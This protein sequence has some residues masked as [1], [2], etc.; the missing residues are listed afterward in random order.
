MIT[1][2]HRLNLFG[3]VPKTCPG[4]CDPHD[5]EGLVM[6]KS[7]GSRIDSSALHEAN[8]LYE[9]LLEDTQAHFEEHGGLKD[10]KKSVAEFFDERIHQGL[11][12]LK[13]KGRDEEFL[14]DVE[15]G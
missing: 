14:E 12:K 15:L 11:D 7:D 2:L 3:D 1:L 6:F 9:A 13:T 10:A 5:N 4:E 8:V